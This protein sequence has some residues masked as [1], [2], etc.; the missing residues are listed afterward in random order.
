MKRLLM[1]SMFCAVAGGAMADYSVRLFVNEDAW[2]FFAFHHDRKIA[3]RA[4]LVREIESYVDTFA[5]GG[6]VTDIAFNVNGMRM[7]YPSGVNET[8]WATKKPD[9]TMAFSGSAQRKYFDLG[10][11]PYALALSRCREKGMRG[12]IS[13]RMNDVHW[14]TASNNLW[15]GTSVWREHPDWLQVT[16]E[17]PAG[18]RRDWNDFAF[19]Y[20]NPAVRDFQFSI[21]KEIVDRYDADGYELDFL[22]WWRH[23]KPGR[24]REDAHFVTEFILRCRAYTREV[25]KRRGHPVQLSSRAPSVYARALELGF[26]VAAWARE[27]A[28]DLIVPCNFFSPIDFDLD[29][30]EW[31]R[32]IAAA[33]PKTLVLPGATDCFAQEPC[34]V[35]WEAWNAWVDRRYRE[36]AQ[37]VYLYNFSYLDAATLDRIKRQGFD[38]ETTG[39]RPRRYVV[40]YHDLSP[41]LP[42]ARILPAYLNHDVNVP[43]TVASLPRDGETAEIVIAIQKDDAPAP[44]VQINGQPVLEKPVR[45]EKARMYGD[46]R[47]SKTVWHYSVA[48]GQLV[49]GR[50][51]VTVSSLGERVFLRWVEIAIR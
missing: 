41:S 40:T 34:R 2:V 8:M 36:G 12:W 44:L 4:G 26:D 5:S 50:N 16:D 22:R 37:G 23:L 9:G 42:P 48:P 6:K 14:V 45:G 21:F 38:P 17:K 1:M 35:R 30:A 46:D 13:M 19:D 27:D 51:L 43:V 15:A 18:S 32:E 11:D 10:L 39:M 31:K 7:G 47:T 20:A 29:F 25:A 33:N 24:E 3:D 49:A 28:V